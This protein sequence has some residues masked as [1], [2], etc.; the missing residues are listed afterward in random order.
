[1]YLCSYG[2]SYNK[3]VK[4]VLIDE[5]KEK[6]KDMEEIKSTLYYLLVR[7]YTTPSTNPRLAA[8]HTKKSTC[9]KWGMEW[10]TDLLTCDRIC[11]KGSST[12]MQYT[13]FDN[14]LLQFGKSY[15]REICSVVCNNIG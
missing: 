11:E 10:K 8:M 2:N 1:M 7:Y 6:F 9:L 15:C 14:S 5:L 3:S 4:M 13:N 12:H